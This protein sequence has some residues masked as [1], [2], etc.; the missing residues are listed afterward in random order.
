[1][2]STISSD[3][4]YSLRSPP[5]SE[6]GRAAGDTRG[7][8][9]AAAGVTLL[10]VLAIASG[11]TTAP[12]R[13]PLAGAAAAAPAEKG[14]QCEMQ[15]VTGSLV[16]TRVCTLAPQRDQIKQS[17]QDARDFLDRQVIGACPGS[18]GCHN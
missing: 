13:A 2:T 10:L 12:R 17:T 1:M 15:R 5:S 16:A 7:R 4:S 14:L 3:G 11:C 18:P 6:S 9:P 8:P